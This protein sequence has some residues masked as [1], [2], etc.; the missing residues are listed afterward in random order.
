MNQLYYFAAPNEYSCGAY[1]ANAY[2]SNQCVGETA[3]APGVP[4]T[5]L[6]PVLTSPYFAIGTVLIALAIVLTVVLR[7]KKR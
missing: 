5:G 7:R 6:E 3:A 2:N 1:G 4:N